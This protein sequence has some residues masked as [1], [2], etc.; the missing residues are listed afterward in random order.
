[1]YRPCGAAGSPASTAGS[2]AGIPAR[3]AGS[4]IGA[5]GGG[6]ELGCTEAGRG[7][8][9]AS[10]AGSGRDCP[11]EGPRLSKGV[12]CGV[13]SST[14]GVL[15]ISPTGV[16]Q[17]ECVSGLVTVSPGEPCYQG[18]WPCRILGRQPEEEL[19]E[20]DLPPVFR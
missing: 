13:C 16:S 19:Q 9:P 11:S 6:G 12:G 18:W 2:G 3:T 1:V 8:S 14:G 15:A 17:V 4:R 10:A 7:G 5:T 20:W